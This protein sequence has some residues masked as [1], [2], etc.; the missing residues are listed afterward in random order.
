LRD[1]AALAEVLSEAAASGSD[2]G[3]MAV[4]ERYRRWRSRDQ[5]EVIAFTDRLSR[6]FSNDFGPLV[7]ARNLGLLALDLATPVKQVFSRRAM[8]LSAGLG[9]GDRLSGHLPRLARGLSLS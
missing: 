9:F 5:G 7:L 3:D 4:L 1:V 8:G 2:P 6:L